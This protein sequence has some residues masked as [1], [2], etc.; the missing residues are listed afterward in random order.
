LLRRVAFWLYTN[1][2]EE[3]TAS[4]FR[5]KKTAIAV[6]TQ[7]LL[8]KLIYKEAG[9]LSRREIVSFLCK[10]RECVC[11]DTFIKQVLGTINE[12]YFPSC[13]LNCMAV[14]AKD[15]KKRI[16]RHIQFSDPFQCKDGR[17]I[18]K[19]ISGK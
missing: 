10:P 8:V 16:I 3:Y 11:D 12:S 6:K 2:S 1:I 14:L 7:I 13:T 9:S 4:I 15:K 19:R 17:I 5:A 18:L